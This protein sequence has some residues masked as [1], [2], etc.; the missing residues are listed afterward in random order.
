MAIRLT[1]RLTNIGVDR[2]INVKIDVT[3]NEKH[4]LQAGKHDNDLMSV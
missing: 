2:K 3:D 1:D 4:E